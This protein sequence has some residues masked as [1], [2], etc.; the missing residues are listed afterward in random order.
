VGFNALFAEA[1]PTK[2]RAH[3][4]GTRNVAFAFTYMAASLLSGYLLDTVSFPINYQIVFG[5]G[6]IGAAMSSFHLYFIKPIHVDE[7][8]HQTP[9]APVTAPQADS[10]RGIFSILRV[11]IL[12]G[13]F[14][15]VLLV[16]LFFHFAHYI[17]TP[18][19]PLYNINELHLTDN[20]MGIGTAMFYLTMFI[21]S[22]QLNRAVGRFGQKNV[23]AYGAMSLALYPGLL[24]LSHEVWQYYVVSLLGGFT[25]AMVGGAYANY[26]LERI[27]PDDRPAHLA[28]YN[29]ALNAAIL[30]SSFVGPLIA[31]ATSLT[32]ALVI[33][34]VLRTLSGLAILRFG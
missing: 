34:A 12:R 27:P 20:N 18:I 7:A 26:M 19:Y 3:V 15:K 23:T 1:V 6:F 30:V 32:I 17:P 14:Q 11:D 33:F 13:P 5:I 2:Y 31:D 25:W 29:I 28:W 21:G 9:P 8:P 24:A 16:L 10:P 4:A 22:M